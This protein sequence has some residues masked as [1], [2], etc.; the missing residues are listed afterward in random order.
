MSTLGELV[1]ALRNMKREA[2]VAVLDAER[3]KR[4]TETPHT[5]QN[6]SLAQERLKTVTGALIAMNEIDRLIE[7][8]A[9]LDETKSRID[10][11]IAELT[12]V[13]TDLLRRLN[14]TKQ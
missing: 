3:A 10:F 7:Q 6:L 12:T 2:Q 5:L 11:R 14:V 13:F 9:Q 4:I 8:R 1:A